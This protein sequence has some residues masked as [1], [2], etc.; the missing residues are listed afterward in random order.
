MPFDFASVTLVPAPL[1]SGEDR[2][3]LERA[4]GPD[5]EA[6]MRSQNAIVLTGDVFFKN[7]C[8]G[9]S[10]VSANEKY[11]WVQ[12]GPMAHLLSNFCHTLW[13]GPGASAHVGYYPQPSIIS[14]KIIEKSGA[15]A[16]LRQASC[17]PDSAGI[18]IKTDGAKLK[19]WMYWWCEDKS[20]TNAKCLGDL[21]RALQPGTSL[22]VYAVTKFIR[23]LNIQ[24]LYA[25]LRY[26]ELPDG[27]LHHPG[28]FAF[29]TIGDH[30]TLFYYPQPDN[31][32]TLVKN[33][34][35]EGENTINKKTFESTPLHPDVVMFHEPI[36]DKT[37]GFSSQML[38]AFE[39]L[40][41]HI[42]P[43]LIQPSFYQPQ[44]DI[45]VS[46]INFNPTLPMEEQVGIVAGMRAYNAAEL[47]RAKGKYA[48]P[49]TQDDDSSGDYHPTPGT[50][51]S[52]SAS[53]A[54]AFDASLPR[55]R[56]RTRTAASGEASGEGDED[57]FAASSS[58][59]TLQPQ[60][61]MQPL[62]T[63]GQEPR[64]RSRQAVEPESP[65]ARLGKT[66][67]GKDVEDIMMLGENSLFLSRSSSPEPTHDGSRGKFRASFHASSH[68][69]SFEASREASLE[70]EFSG[71]TLR[72]STRLR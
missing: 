63:T 30:F 15:V 6:L 22:R 70:A 32:S 47:A 68:T 38:Y 37:G 59:I 8:R 45:N 20:S 50:P 58:Q 12:Y 43:I 11:E 48:S 16:D 64:R 7:L 10:L 57:V 2:Q 34:G 4:A 39:L 1:T 61:F 26:D 65:S 51:E 52:G 14:R 9:F 17:T 33:A 18:W 28:F 56:Y 46:T 24:A 25:F 27:C 29:L 62:P 36:L 21:G 72:R 54:G 60:Q 67:K 53:E 41:R 49:E 71:I 55:T 23:Q 69:D 66:G 44:A 42:N 31:W 19:S 13:F 40:R 35:G 5:G 3:D